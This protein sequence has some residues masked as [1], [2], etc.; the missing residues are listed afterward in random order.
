[1]TK[2]LPGI[3]LV[4]LLVIQLKQPVSAPSLR[5]GASMI[6]ERS[7]TH[8]LRLSDKQGEIEL[9][10]GELFE[11]DGQKQA[12]SSGF[13]WKLHPGKNRLRVQPCN[14]LG[15]QGI[16]SWIALEYGAL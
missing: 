14:V 1:M 13:I 5:L 16:P 2:R 12:V 10:S 15:R 4:G 11:D 3:I 8:H 9:K 6:L 7:V